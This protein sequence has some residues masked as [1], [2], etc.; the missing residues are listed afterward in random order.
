MYPSQLLFLTIRHHLL[1]LFTLSRSVTV[2][3]IGEF[4]TS[5]LELAGQWTW[6]QVKEFR[7]TFILY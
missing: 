1:L 3:N 7:Y 2:G 4:W 5:V 6:L